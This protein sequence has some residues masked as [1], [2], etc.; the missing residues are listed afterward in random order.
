MAD[1]TVTLAGGA[2]L[3]LK[4][5]SSF[6]SG[7]L[8]MLRVQQ[9]FAT[10]LYPQVCNEL[11]ELPLG[12]QIF[13]WLIS[14]LLAFNAASV[15]FLARKQRV[16]Q[17]AFN[18]QAVCSSPWGWLAFAFA[19]SSGMR[20]YAGG[21]LVVPEH[22]DWHVFGLMVLWVFTLVSLLSSTR[23]NAPSM[24]KPRTMP[25][26]S[27]LIGKYYFLN[28]VAIACSAICYRFFVAEFLRA[29]DTSAEFS[30]SLQAVFVLFDSL[31]LARTAGTTFG[32]G[33]YSKAEKKFASRPQLARMIYLK[34][35]SSYLAFIA[36]ISNLIY[37]LLGNRDCDFGLRAGILGLAAVISVIPTLQFISYVADNIEDSESAAEAETFIEKQSP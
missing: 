28:L 10:V 35:F 15:G 20:T 4:F 24:V 26:A 31:S 36:S 22:K 19:T 14:G 9:Q 29:H 30:V 33:W 2:L 25:E 21:H 11:Y 37:D 6:F 5:I 32:E 12:G 27:A 7:C 13:I 17:D 34:A 1:K 8:L 3:S 18:W 23:Y 16:G